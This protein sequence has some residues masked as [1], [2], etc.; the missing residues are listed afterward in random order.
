MNE[1]TFF[2]KLENSLFVFYFSSV[3]ER[4]IKS[5]YPIKILKKKK[6]EI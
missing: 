5:F 6:S 2:K 4:R 3:N 1:K